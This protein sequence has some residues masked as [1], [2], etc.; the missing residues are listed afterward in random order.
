MIKSWIL[1]W[2]ECVAK[3]TGDEKKDNGPLVLAVLVASW[4]LANFS[5]SAF[6]EMSARKIDIQFST[7][8]NS[9]FVH[10]FILP[11]ERSKI[12]R[13]LVSSL[14]GGSSRRKHPLS[15][16]DHKLWNSTHWIAF[17][18]HQCKT[19]TIVISCCWVHVEIWK[20]VSDCKMFSVSDMA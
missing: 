4:S 12:T 16:W 18:E 7:R 11:I 17:N 14:R 19:M 13:V 5:E 20:A 10:F 1:L 6:K 9:S 15:Q 2:Y 3:H 8:L